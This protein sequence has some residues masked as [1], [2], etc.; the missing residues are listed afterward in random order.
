MKEEKEA[1]VAFTQ[2]LPEGLLEKLDALAESNKMSRNALVEA[3]LA[4]VVDDKRFV[5]KVRR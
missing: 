2:R 5:L 4:Q 3:I 1:P